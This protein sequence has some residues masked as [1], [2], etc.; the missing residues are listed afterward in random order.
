MREVMES[1]LCVLP[2]PRMIHALE[3]LHL[4]TVRWLGMPSAVVN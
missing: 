4:Q 2:T 1:M 3:Q